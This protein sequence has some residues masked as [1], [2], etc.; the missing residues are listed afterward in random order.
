MSQ[1]KVKRME[2]IKLLHY[3][4]ASRGICNLCGVK[5]D[6]FSSEHVYAWGMEDAIGFHSI[7]GFRM[8]GRI[9]F[10][11]KKPHSVDKEF[12][13]ADM[14]NP[15]KVA[16]S[17]LAFNTDLQFALF[18]PIRFWIYFGHGFARVESLELPLVFRLLSRTRLKFRSE[19][20]NMHINIPT[21]R[22]T[23]T[24]IHSTWIYSPRSG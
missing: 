19:M 22:R 1:I 17:K 14:S 13:I 20:T 11:Y 18:L 12:A 7:I 4:F 5:I 23:H 24:R 15:H 10:S 21:L 8:E 3:L 16:C 2:T 9:T 6:Y